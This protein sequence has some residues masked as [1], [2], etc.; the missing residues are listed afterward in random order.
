MLLWTKIE[1]R[2]D[3][4]VIFCCRNGNQR[5]SRWMLEFSE[6][7]SDKARACKRMNNDLKFN[8]I[9]FSKQT[10]QLFL[11]LLHGLEVTY[12]TRCEMLKL[13]KF[14]TYEGKIGTYETWSYK[15]FTDTLTVCCDHK[16]RKCS[17]LNRCFKIWITTV[18]E[19]S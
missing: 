2:N 4:E 11:D 16:G 6:F 19:L 17:D 15:G 7:F 9:Q 1:Q 5:V 8:Y 13:I 3:L 12:L 18:Y 10:V 14:L